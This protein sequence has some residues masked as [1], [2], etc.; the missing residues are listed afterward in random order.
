MVDEISNFRKIF[1][2]NEKKNVKSKTPI[3]FCPYW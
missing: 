1:N 3:S 2:N